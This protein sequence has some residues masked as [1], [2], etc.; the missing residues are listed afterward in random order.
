[1]F[2]RLLPLFHNC[3]NRKT[4]IPLCRIYLFTGLIIESSFKIANFSLSKRK[5]F[6]LESSRRKYLFRS[7]FSFSLRHVDLQILAYSKLLGLILPPQCYY[8]IY[9]KNT[10]VHWFLFVF[11]FKVPLNCYFKPL[12]S[13]VVY[14]AAAVLNPDTHGII[15]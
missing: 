3:G 9:L 2:S 6:L 15:S 7:F 1:M 8:V 5:T 12:T 13:E 4:W 14:Q 10:L 11:N